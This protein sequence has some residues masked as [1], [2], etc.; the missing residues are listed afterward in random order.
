MTAR[1]NHLRVLAAIA[2]PAT[3]AIV[4]LLAF[5]T[6]PANATGTQTIQIPL[7]WC[8]LNG[9]TAATN[10]NSILLQRQDRAA[11]QIWM[12]GANITFRPPLTAAIPPSSANFPVIS[13]PRPPV[14]SPANPNETGLGPGQV[15]DILDPDSRAAAAELHEARAE[16]EEEWDKFALPPPA[17][18]G[19]KLQGPI[20]LNI[21]RFVDNNGSP[22]ARLGQGEPPTSYGATRIPAEDPI[23]PSEANE[24]EDADEPGDSDGPGDTEDAEPDPRCETPPTDSR[25]SERMG[26]LAWPT[27]RLCRTRH[28]TRG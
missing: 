6:G 4:C 16:C 7:R 17:G 8:A 13:D 9:T 21:R 1:S 3:V 19:T 15:G 5:A 20:A 27:S 28:W 22:V 23:P 26:S 18:F 10:T 12:P 11:S 25:G 14:S 2:L 24:T